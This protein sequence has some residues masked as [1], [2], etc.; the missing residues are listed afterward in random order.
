MCS[1]FIWH[2]LHNIFHPCYYVNISSL[3][4]FCCC[5]SVVWCSSVWVYHRL[6]IQ[7]PVMSIV[8]KP[9]RGYMLSMLWGT[10]LLNKIYRRSLVWTELLQRNQPIKQ[11]Q[12][13]VLKFHVTR[14]KLNCL[15][16]WE[17][18]RVRDNSP[19]LPKPVLTG[20]KEL[21]ASCPLLPL[22]L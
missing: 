12:S 6:P 5:S 3:G 9:L 4:F 2:P 11:K 13:L 19:I 18:K 21:C 7:S 16:S 8:R 17:I 15:A 22:P 14:Q 20:M 10:Y 1:F